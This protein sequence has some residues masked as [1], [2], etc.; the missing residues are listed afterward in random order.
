MSENVLVSEKKDAL[1]LADSG[2]KRSEFMVLVDR[3]LEICFDKATNKYL[4]NQ[5]RQGWIR[6]ATGLLKVGSDVLADQDIEGL[7]L[8]ITEIEKKLG[9][10]QNE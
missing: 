10:K 3:L 9:G 4:R 7:M 2:H 6:V 5:E 8:R 1:K